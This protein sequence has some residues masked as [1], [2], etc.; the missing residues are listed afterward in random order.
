MRY[1]I[2]FAAMTYLFV[3]LRNLESLLI[4]IIFTACQRSIAIVDVAFCLPSSLCHALLLLCQN[5]TRSR[6]LH[7]SSN[8]YRKLH[9]Q[10]SRRYIPDRSSQQYR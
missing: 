2:R 7:S 9:L 10:S 4:A 6:C 8:L 1:V 5:D 3:I